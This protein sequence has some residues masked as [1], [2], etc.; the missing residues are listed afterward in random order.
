[1]LLKCARCGSAMTAP[2]AGFGE[3]DGRVYPAPPSTPGLVGA[4]RASLPGGPAT[5][6]HWHVLRRLP[7]WHPYSSGR[8]A[9]GHVWFACKAAGL[10]HAHPGVC[11]CARGVC[12]RL[13][14]SPSLLTRGTS[15]VSLEGSCEAAQ[16][17]RLRG[18]AAD[19]ATVDKIQG[20]SI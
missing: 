1:M 18:A 19:E 20:S 6:G 11:V 17:L 14:P 12:L 9:E 15:N 2:A 8:L 7:V 3:A 5:D 4:R 16:R 10:A 13:L